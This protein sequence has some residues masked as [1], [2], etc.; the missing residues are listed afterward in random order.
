MHVARS[1]RAIPS[2][3]RNRQGM[4][5]TTL[6]GLLLAADPP[7]AAEMERILDEV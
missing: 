5:H 7:Q 3:E 1:R 6:L 4:D 2:P